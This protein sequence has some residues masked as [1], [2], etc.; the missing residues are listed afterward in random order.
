MWQLR[1]GS[2]R[3][4]HLLGLGSVS[5]GWRT[6]KKDKDKIAMG[7]DRQRDLSR[8]EEVSGNE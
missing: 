4:E 3:L 7:V 5:I 8:M 1:Q 6:K 2:K